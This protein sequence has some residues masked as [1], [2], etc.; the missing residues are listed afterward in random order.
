V[1]LKRNV[2]AMALASAGLCFTVGIQAAPAG[3]D[4]GAPAATQPAA[5]ASAQDA[6]Q[7]SAAQ[8]SEPQDGRKKSNEEQL[9][10]SLAGITV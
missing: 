6:P 8:T 5:S 1:I 3:T 7:S 2:L 4:N 9:A 10:K